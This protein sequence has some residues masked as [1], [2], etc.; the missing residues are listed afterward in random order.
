MKPQLYKKLVKFQV[1]LK[2]NSGSIMAT[3][4]Q[5]HIEKFFSISSTNL[6]KHTTQFRGQIMLQHVITS[7][8]NDDAE[9]SIITL[10]SKPHQQSV[11]IE[12]KA[13]KELFPSTVGTNV[14]SNI[15]AA[16][17]GTNSTSDISATTSVPST[18]SL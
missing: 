8:N 7:V 11:Q 5:D 13:K 18:K 9:P 4:F 14:A 10:A 15:S 2:D 1:E 3:I 12:P 6:M 16:V 17:V